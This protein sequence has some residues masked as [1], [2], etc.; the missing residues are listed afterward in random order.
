VSERHH[1]N[2][3]EG[4]RLKPCHHNN[5]RFR[6]LAPGADHM[7]YLQKFAAKLMPV[8]IVLACASSQAQTFSIQHLHLQPGER[9]TNIELMATAGAFESI[10]PMPVGWSFTID[11]DPSWRTSVEASIHVGAA[12]LSETDLEC[13]Q[14]RM[15]KGEFGDLKFSLTGKIV[16]TKDFTHTRRIVLTPSNFKSE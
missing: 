6:A 4:A 16:V 8:V 9:I 11:N 5:N 12:A 14:I 13:L 1:S 10:T 7:A 2:K 15:K 3:L